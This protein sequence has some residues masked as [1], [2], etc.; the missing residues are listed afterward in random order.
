MPKARVDVGGGGRRRAGDDVTFLLAANPGAPLLPLAKV[1][2]GGELAR[3]ML[4]LRLV[5]CPRPAD[6]DA[7][8]PWSSTRSTPASAGRPPPAVGEA[9]AR[10]GHGDHQVLVVTHL[11]QVA[12]WAD[13]P[14]HG[15]QG[16]RASRHHRL[17]APGCSTATS[18]SVEL[19]RMLSG[20]P[21][22]RHRPHATPPSC[23]PA[24]PPPR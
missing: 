2:S 12:A 16:R 24:P 9:L 21:G 17:R 4:A 19:A 3:T 20:S 15:G 5:L 11:P 22:L 18:G 6:T 23:S 13:D 8:P 7:R 10:L 14:G 1:A